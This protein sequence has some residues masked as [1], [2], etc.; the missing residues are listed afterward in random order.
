MSRCAGC[1]K[2][3]PNLEKLTNPPIY[4][5]CMLLWRGFL[6]YSLSFNST[7]R[8]PSM[9]Y[10][11]I[12]FLILLMCLQPPLLSQENVDSLWQELNQPMPD[13]T[14]LKLNEQVLQ[15]YKDARNY[16]QLGLRSEEMLEEHRAKKDKNG[17]QLAML[18]KSI[19]LN[20]N[21]D[22]DA[23]IQMSKEGAALCYEIADSLQA[24]RHLTN[25]GVFLQLQG[26]KDSALAFY[27]E[28]Y[29]IYNQYKAYKPLSRILN[30]IA[31]LYRQKE[32]YD[33]AIRI[34]N[35]S[36]TIRQNLKDTL[37]I[38]TT[39]MNMG[40]LYSYTDQMDQAIS[41]LEKAA[42]IFLQKNVQDEV[43][44]CNNVLG[45]IYYNLGCYPEARGYLESA[46][47][48]YQEN[49]NIW[50]QA[51]NAFS[52]GSVELIQRNY[53][54]SEQYLEEC[55][56]LS[57]AANRWGDK[58][59]IFLKLS[60]VKHELGKDTEAYEALLTAYEH[61][62]SVKEERRLELTEENLT[63]FE[64]LQKEKELALNQLE[65]E[66]RTRQRDQLIAG[67][68]LLLFLATGLFFFLRQR[69]LIG[70]QQTEL[71]HQRIQQ[72]EQEKKLTALN[73][74]IEGEE[75]ERLRLATDL[76]DG[77]GSLLT[78]VKSHH[79]QLFKATD[80]QKIYN[81][82]SLLIDEACSEIRRISY[83][84]APRALSVAG[85]GGAIEDLC[86]SIKNQGADCE[87]EIIGL[88]E[89]QLEQQSIHIYRI[90][91]ELC[92][93]SLKHADSETLFVQLFQKEGFLS[94][95]VEDEGK[96]FDYRK[97]LEHKGLG[98][99]S[100]ESRVKALNGSIHWYSEPDEGTSVSVRI[101]VG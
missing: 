101:P 48:Y 67:F 82:T 74:I 28:S 75:K 59:A 32:A 70:R 64:V 81:K 8:Q 1:K 54:Q 5:R 63:R 65:L 39:Y 90:L 12:F 11:S 13:S 95:L 21:G 73:A 77:L 91:Q 69:I 86:L 51:S 14:R 89:N 22:S 57:Q 46:Y 43:A 19:V 85:L 9:K 37:G 52:L 36:L 20:Y 26:Q 58:Q 98:L 45:T 17:M 49:P 79:T 7:Y 61:L 42:A 83:N 41:H 96:G 10:N 99:S 34:Y 27:L 78:A 93:N 24:A 68:I 66:R 80:Q 100:V 56:Q 72:L 88:E 23:A 60:K 38:A 97:T 55:I 4:P 87:L 6:N 15:A 84:M 2:Q 44:N 16:E 47:R 76:H 62:D 40:L 3:A 94:I 50:Y 33:K 71:Q 29:P 53:P 25:V 31:I 35:E 92:N 30:N 18:Y